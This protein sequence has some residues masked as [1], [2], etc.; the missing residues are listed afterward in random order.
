MS[1]A[2]ALTGGLRL[3]RLAG[4][5]GAQFLGAVAASALLALIL[6]DVANLGSTVPQGG[7][8]ESVGMEAACTALLVLVIMASRTADWEVSV[9]PALA[10]GATVAAASLLLGPVSGGSL[11]PARSL[12]PAF[13]SGTWEHQWVYVLGPIAGAAIGIAIHQ[14]LSQRPRPAP[15]KDTFAGA[16][17]ATSTERDG[18]SDEHEALIEAE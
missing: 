9:S 13:I 14:I 17:P 10:I 18:A 12:G 6:G 16:P 1:L 7:P 5:I 2:F 15:A 11:N 3:T 4:Y 8:W